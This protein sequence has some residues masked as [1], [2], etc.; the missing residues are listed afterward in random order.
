M[1]NEKQKEYSKKHGGEIPVWQSP[2][3]IESRQKAIEVIESHKYGIEY[4]DFWILM[5]ETNS[6]KMAY[7]GLIISHN[8]CLKI[9]DALPAELKFDPDSVSI[10]E[11]G[12][13]NS[14]VFFYTNKAQ[15]LFEV[16]EVSAANCKIAYPY[17]MAVKRLFDRVVLKNSKLAYAGIYGEDEADEFK[18]PDPPKTEETTIYVCQDCKK[19]ITDYTSTDGQTRTVEELVKHSQENYGLNLCAACIKK[20]NAD[21]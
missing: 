18:R 5:N 10:N 7:T 4:G 21:K 9:N 8:G 17:A 16:G 13:G 1:F 19:P 11:S 12:Y 3:Y 2:K 6:G 15:G 14:L 20:H